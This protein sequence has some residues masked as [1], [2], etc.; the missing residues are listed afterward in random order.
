RRQR[1][2]FAALAAAFVLLVAVLA[3]V[4]WLAVRAERARREAEQRRRQA[5]SLVGFMLGDPHQPLGQGHRL[6]V[7]D[8]AGDHALAYFDAVPES[9]LS[10]AELAH[11]VEAIDQI[12]EVRYAQGNLPAAQAAF[13]R[14]RALARDLVERNPSNPRWQLLLWEVGSWAGQ[15]PF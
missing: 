11:R 2:R 8:G 12:G 15:V 7:L 1:L 9:Q 6:D 3:V 5:E 13:A 10:S 14:S 4:S